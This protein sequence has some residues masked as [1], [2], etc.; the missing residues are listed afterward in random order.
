MVTATWK[1]TTTAVPFVSDLSE[2]LARH[3]E[4][5]PDRIAVGTSDL[6]TTITYRQL[7]T[8]VRSAMAQLSRMGL[9]RGNTVAL[10][11]D[12]SVDF[13]VGLLAI[14]FSGGRVAPLNPALTS[15][16]LSTR[17][18]ALSAKATLF[19]KHH[20]GQ[21]ENWKSGSAAR[22]IMTIK[23]SLAASTV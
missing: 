12:N 16:E 4:Q 18:S 19:P 10:I 9:K 22:W 23:I 15:N 7:D 20:T 3:V 6:Q 21:L 2:R 5:Q 1:I 17:V 14:I 11:S 13:V 8:L